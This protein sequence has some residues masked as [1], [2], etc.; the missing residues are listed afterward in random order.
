MTLVKQRGGN[1]VKKLSGAFEGLKEED[2]VEEVNMVGGYWIKKGDAF[3]PAEWEN[4]DEDCW[5]GKDV[6][7]KYEYAL[8]EDQVYEIY[9]ALASTH[10]TVLQN[11]KI[12]HA[13]D[14]LRTRE[15]P[16]QIHADLLTLIKAKD[17]KNDFQ[18]ET[19]YYYYDDE[20]KQH[21]ITE[22]DEL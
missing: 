11:H 19:F 5:V 6:F 21:K 18:W 22:E 9:K 1:K 16:T 3:V 4:T 13:T 2:L 12:N 15:L 17:C 20:G 7:E 14:L 8:T 10:G